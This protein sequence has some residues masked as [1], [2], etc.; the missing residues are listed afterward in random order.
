MRRNKVVL[1][2][3]TE[4]GAVFEAEDFEGLVT[5]MKLDMW[6]VPKTREEYMEGVA[7]RSEIYNGE[8]IEYYDEQSFIFELV[9]IGVIKELWVERRDEEGDTK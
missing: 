2:A 4:D 3:K 1:V 5:A 9:R 7:R 6:F 8:R